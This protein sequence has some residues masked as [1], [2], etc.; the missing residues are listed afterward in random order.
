MGLLLGEVNVSCHSFLWWVRCLDGRY[1][2]DGGG[3]RDVIYIHPKCHRVLEK[4]ID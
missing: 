4:G 1:G 2:V 3:G